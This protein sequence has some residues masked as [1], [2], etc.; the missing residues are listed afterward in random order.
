MSK[1]YFKSLHS[2]FT[3]IEALIALNLIGISIYFGSSAI[4]QL[5]KVK[6]NAQLY[7]NVN[8][9][10]RNLISMLQNNT[11]WVYTI[12]G[13][14]AEFDCLKN[15]TGGLGDAGCEVKNDPNGYPFV[16]YNDSNMVYYDPVGS[17]TAGF[18]NK[19]EVCNTYDS[20]N[21]NPACPYRA[22]VRWRPIC[23]FAPGV[24][25]H[26]PAIEIT[27]LIE[28]KRS[29]NVFAIQKT[30]YTFQVIRPYVNCPTIPI[31]FLASSA[32]WTQNPSPSSGIINATYLT[33]TNTTAPPG[34]AF[35]FTSNIYSCEDRSLNFRQAMQI[36]GSAL[37][38]DANNVST[39][40]FSDPN[41]SNKC[42][43]EWRHTQTTWSLWQRNLS[44]DIMEKV[45]DK[46]TGG[47]KPQFNATTVFSF[48][49][50][51]GLV[52]FL[53][54]SELYYIFSQPWLRNYSYRITPPPA[55]YSRGIEPL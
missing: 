13:N 7:M 24:K 38:E 4:S 30:N 14:G 9:S 48:T 12:N 18:D 26:Q 44:T 31:N 32:N 54:D 11:A 16:L 20:T 5:T 47:A 6:T 50:K 2:G 45:Y 43:Y 52:Q 27:G 23:S 19:G 10:K 33:T 17:A 36:T 1:K 42:I 15:I 46:P 25:C 34:M 29:T 39:V 49:S 22:Q 51:K 55:N 37:P 53:V 21:G 41:Q 40:C 8:L 35:E 28:I 3:L